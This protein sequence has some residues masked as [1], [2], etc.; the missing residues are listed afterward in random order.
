MF[1][2]LLLTPSQ[3]GT[4][5]VTIHIAIAAITPIQKSYASVKIPIWRTI[6]PAPPRRL[7]RAF[8]AFGDIIN[9]QFFNLA[10]YHDSSMI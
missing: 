5:T 6:T 8:L 7:I 2:N 1:I 9:L 10:F 4:A 3:V